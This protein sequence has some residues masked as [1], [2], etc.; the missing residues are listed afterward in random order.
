MVNVRSLRRCPETRSDIG[1]VRSRLPA[2]TITIGRD[3]NS[4]RMNGPVL[5]I[6]TADATVSKALDSRWSARM[7]TSHNRWEA[8]VAGLLHLRAT[9]IAG[10][11]PVLPPARR[12]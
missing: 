10:E 8:L 7:P 3:V 6:E 1:G 2:E 9:A 5:V 12:P 11:P 4:I